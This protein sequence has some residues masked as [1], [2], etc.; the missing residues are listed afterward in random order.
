MNIRGFFTK[1]KIIWTIIILLV[2]GF[3]V[4]R[5]KSGKSTAGNI[6]TAVATKQDLQ[7][8]VLSTGQVVSGTDLQL[9]FK[10]G[11]VVSVV[12]VQAGDKVKAGQV[13]ATVDQSTQAANLTTAR[14]SLAQ[15]QAAYQKVIAGS[16]S[17]S[18][19]VAQVNLSNAQNSLQ[20]ATSQQQVQVSNAYSALLNSTL[21]AVAGSGNQDTVTATVSGTYT[22]ADQGVYDISI[23]STGGGEGFKYSGLENGSGIVSTSPQPLGTKGL[24]IKFSSNTF[25]SYD[26]W[27]LAVPN[28]QATNYVAN[29]NAY[30]AALQTQ[31]SQVAAAQNAVAAA[32]AALNLQT[33]AAQPADV[34]SAQAQILVAQGQVQAA[35]AA[36]SN[37]VITAPVSGTITQV[38]IK[39]G[40]Q[41]NASQEVLI[42]Q[43]VSDLHAE[44]DVSEADIASIQSGQS[45]DYTFDALG[46]D[47][48]F[49]GTVLT[50]NPASTVVSGVVNY[51]VKATL[52]NIPDIKPG[53]TVNMTVLVAKKTGVLAVPSSAIINQNNNQYVRVVDDIKKGTYHQVQVQTGLNADGGMVEITSGLSE[54]ETIVTYIKQ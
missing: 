44:A 26:T 5:V 24:L 36:L 18:I 1:K 32:Q 51:L 28:T 37:T 17:A 48:H 47:R 30:Q 2:A 39:V 8:T 33:Q 12:K 22:G 13:L 19:Q 16:S 38:D 52:P 31:A 35:Q 53:M 49:A 25:S 23:Y 3:I 10:T 9:S 42:L 41:A 15:A 21:S 4:Y 50:V 11:G 14:G 27:T 34:A 40:E 54:G 43:D 20:A 6:Q 29:Y 7:Q 45:V 46:P